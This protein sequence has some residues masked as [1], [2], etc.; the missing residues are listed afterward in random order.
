MAQVDGCPITDAME[1]LGK[2]W[3]ILII[4]QLLTGSKRFC[5]LENEMNISGRLLSER[6]KDLEA[7]GLVEKKVYPDIPVRIEYELTTQGKKIEPIIREM[8]AWSLEHK[9][10]K[11][12]EHI[13]S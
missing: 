12:G 9:N 6:L 5:Q 11:K 4:N 10:S 8:Y 3:V 7:E 1:I 13:S 2:K